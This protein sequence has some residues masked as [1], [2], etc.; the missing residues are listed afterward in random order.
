M[1]DNVALF[2]VSWEV[3]NKVGG[4][5]TVVKSKAARMVEGYKE[6]YFVVGPYF[7]NKA[8]GEFQEKL[9]PDFLKAAFDAVKAEG[10]VCH[11]GEWLVEGTPNAILID[12]TGFTSRTNEIKKEL[13]DIYKIDS[14]GTEYFDFDEP[15][16]WSYASGKLV[17][18]FSKSRKVIAH[19]HEWLSGA[20][21]LYLKSRKANAATVFTTHAT[22]LG[23]TMASADID[24]YSVFGKVNPDNEAYRF[25][26]YPKHQVEKSAAQ[27]ADVFTTVSEVTGLEATSLLGRKPEIILPNGLNLDKFPTFE[28]ASI[29][30]DHLKR[31]IKEFIT[32]YFFPYYTFDLDETLIYFLSGRYEFHDKGVDIFIKGLAKL[33]NRLKQ[34]KSQRTVVAFFWIPGNIKSI[35]A[36]LLESKTFYQDVKESVDDADANV[37]ERLIRL[38][39][40]QKKIDSDALLG[41]D[42]EFELKRKVMRL[43]RKGTPPLSTHDLYNEDSDQILSLFRKLGLNNA[44]NDRVKV[45]FYPIYLTGADRLLDLNYYEAME[46]SHLGVFP[47]FYEPWGY[48][49]LEAAALGVSSVTTDL[50]GFGRYIARDTQKKREPGVFVVK[51]LGRSDD[52][53]VDDLAEIMYRYSK[54]TKE[55]RIKNKIEAK[56]AAGHADWKNLVKNYFDAHQL[57]LKKRFGE[58]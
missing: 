13:W 32:Y 58:K 39:I 30:H 5:Y 2:E 38:S 36:E 52:N 43:F 45:V 37:R 47:S 18:S 23:R 55:E 4:I 12:F 14:L 6:S 56:H 48:T 19:F 41:K 22:M 44:E 9:P 31:R 34:E 29:K 35:K 10:I 25:K 27:N 15:V 28:D 1:T 46:G 8:I 11:Y 40:S 50:A 57:A 33:N 7:V 54:L 21:L 42:L 26:V 24:L 3:C 20:G 51:R 49:P 53:V 16:V 17:E